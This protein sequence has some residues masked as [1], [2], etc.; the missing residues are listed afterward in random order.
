MSDKI[1]VAGCKPIKKN[2]G[3]FHSMEKMG[4]KRI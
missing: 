4:T 1:V 2:R 3:R